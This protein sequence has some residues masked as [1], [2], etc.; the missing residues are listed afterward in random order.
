MTRSTTTSL[1]DPP[2]ASSPTGAQPGPSPYPQP[3]PD[4]PYLDRGLADALKQLPS[5]TPAT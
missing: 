3:T 2:P 5:R 1:T 4:D